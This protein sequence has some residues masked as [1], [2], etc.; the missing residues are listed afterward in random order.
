MP[1]YVANQVYDSFRAGV[2]QVPLAGFASLF[3]PFDKPLAV[4]TLDIDV[5]REECASLT[6]FK[7]FFS[8]EKNAEAFAKQMPWIVQPGE[9][10]Y[11]SPGQLAIP[12]FFNMN[13]D[14]EKIGSDFAVQPLLGPTI[15]KSLEADMQE[16]IV[17]ANKV[18]LSR[19]ATSP[20]WKDTSVAFDLFTAP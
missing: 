10:L 12:C 14:Q 19:V 18:H 3:Q 15:Q 17:Q 8:A 4:W 5:V 7:P 1:M 11:V 9:V 20:S 2:K 13:D 16:C 6:Q